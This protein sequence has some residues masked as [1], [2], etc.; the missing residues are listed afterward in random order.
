M[1]ATILL[2]TLLLWGASGLLVAG[3]SLNALHT[4]DLDSLTFDED[5][6]QAVAPWNLYL[7]LS[8]I[9][10]CILGLIAIVKSI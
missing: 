6:R 3:M 2:L 9:L 8:G 5:L 7:M 10:L 1:M 4:S